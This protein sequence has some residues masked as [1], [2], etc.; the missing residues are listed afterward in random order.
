MVCPQSSG[1][2][3]NTD[4]YEQ[5]INIGVLNMSDNLPKYAFTSSIR[6]GETMMIVRGEQGLQWDRQL[7][8][9]TPYDMNRL[10]G[11]TPEQLKAMEIGALFGWDA[12]GANPDYH[13]PLYQKS[14][15]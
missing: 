13:K 4:S 1:L 15:V 14:R 11:V 6:T 2:F 9:V 7:K 3:G 8:H 5:I 12:K 10:H